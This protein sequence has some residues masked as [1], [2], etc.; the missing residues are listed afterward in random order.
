MPCCQIGDGAPVAVQSAFRTALSRNQISVQMPLPDPATR[1]ANG[2]VQT[3]QSTAAD[4]SV[5]TYLLTA[6]DQASAAYVVT[7]ALLAT[8]QSMGGP[9]GALGYPLSDASAGGRSCSRTGRCPAV[10]FTW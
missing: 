10:R 1:T 6:A 3:V 4:G 9:A 2:Y 5:T 7:G 8:Y